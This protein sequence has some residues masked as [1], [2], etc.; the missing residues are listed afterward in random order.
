M[1]NEDIISETD[2]TTVGETAKKKF[3]GVVKSIEWHFTKPIAGPGG[4]TR[5]VKIVKR[6]T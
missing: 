5:S 2:D 6:F 4:V 3:R 1:Q